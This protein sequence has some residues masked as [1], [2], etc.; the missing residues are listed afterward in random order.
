MFA[1]LKNRLRM[2]KHIC[3]FCKWEKFCKS[4]TTNDEVINNFHNLSTR[5]NKCE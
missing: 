1:R 4:E 2:C 3:L 5:F